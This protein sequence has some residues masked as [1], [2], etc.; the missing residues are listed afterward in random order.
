M[1]K[2]EQLKELEKQKQ[3]YME[4]FRDRKE[5]NYVVISKNLRKRAPFFEQKP[6][7]KIVSGIANIIDVPQ[8]FKKDLFIEVL[9]N[10]GEDVKLIDLITLLTNE[11]SKQ[12]SKT[13]AELQDD[14]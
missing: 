6:D 8:Q 5:Y 2:Y 7:T 4:F 9:K 13:F 14:L 11:D 10:F 1:T 3:R 12:I